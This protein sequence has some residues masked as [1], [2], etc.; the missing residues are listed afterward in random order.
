MS[1]I[2]RPNRQKLSIANL[3]TAYKL[4]DA[5]YCL[6]PTLFFPSSPASLSQKKERNQKQNTTMTE[7]PPP[8]QSPDCAPHEVTQDN[9][10]QGYEDDTLSYLPDEGFDDWSPA[11]TE[12]FVAMSG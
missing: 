12:R 1:L 4:Q 3:G 8:P 2:V 9:P 10:L 7:P 5:L 6:G 11:D